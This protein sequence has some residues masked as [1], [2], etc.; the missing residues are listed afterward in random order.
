MWR[1]LTA[2]L[3]ISTQLLWKCWLHPLKGGCIYLLS[4]NRHIYEFVRMPIQ[5][6]DTRS[7]NILIAIDCFCTCF[8]CL[9]PEIQH[10]SQESRNVVDVNS[11]SVKVRLKDLYLGDK[12]ARFRIVSP[13][14][15]ISLAIGWRLVQG[16]PYRSPEAAGKKSSSQATPV[17]HGYV[18]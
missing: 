5:T 3:A 7:I 14:Q 18:D 4:N 6:V 1:I 16:V 2:V 17:T 12:Q 11:L 8:C 13:I 10:I 9:M 15:Y